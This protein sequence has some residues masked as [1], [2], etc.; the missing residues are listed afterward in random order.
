MFCSS[1]RCTN[2][3]LGPGDSLF[4]FTSCQ[5]RQEKVGQLERPREEASVH[6]F[7]HTFLFTKPSTKCIRDGGE[8]I[9]I[10]E[11]LLLYFIVHCTKFLLYPRFPVDNSTCRRLCRSTR[12]SPSCWGSSTQSCL[13]AWLVPQAVLWQQQSRTRAVLGRL[14]A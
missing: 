8:G 14:V 3:C 11:L 4:F 7:P 12:R 6:G 9:S 10:I 1:S 2:F 5:G 13:L